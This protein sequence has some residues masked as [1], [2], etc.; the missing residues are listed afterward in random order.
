[1]NRGLVLDLGI[2]SGVPSQL[3]NHHSDS[4]FVEI[5]KFLHVQTEPLSYFH[6]F[7]HSENNI[8][9]L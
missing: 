6:F 7:N 5:I 1:M 2:P 9:I 8:L 3:Y 4:N